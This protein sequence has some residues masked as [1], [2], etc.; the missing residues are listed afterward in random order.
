MQEYIKFANSLINKSQPVHLTFFI[1]ARC[2]AKC[3]MCFYWKNLNRQANELSLKEIRSISENMGHILWLMLTGGEPFLRSGDLPEIAELFYR[4]CKPKFI[5]IPTNGLLVDE[6]ED[7]TEKI[8]K[9]CKSSDIRIKIS[10]DGVGKENDE[11]RGVDGGF[12][13]AVETYKRL[14]GLE[15]KY[16]NLYTG[17]T[18]TLSSFNRQN[19]TGLIDFVTGF[20]S[21]IAPAMNYVRGCTRDDLARSISLEEF[22]CSYKYLMQKLSKKYKEMSLSQKILLASEYTGKEIAVEIAKKGRMVIPCYAGILSIVITE[23]GE[24]YPCEILDKSFGNLRDNDYGIRKILNSKKA[25]SLKKFINDKRCHCTHECNMFV[26]TLF[27]PRI[28]PRIA[29]KYFEFSLSRHVCR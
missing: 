24:V 23:E 16:R 11:I 20:K 8:L 17:F 26:N 13:R 1:T 4:N 12:E 25:A 9:I 2:N 5:T 19:I 14:S 22:E 21:S 10:L 3:K 28:Y 7:T 27:N 29:G 18:M 6:I 15:K